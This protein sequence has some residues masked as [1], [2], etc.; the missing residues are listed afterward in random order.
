MRLVQSMK[1]FNQVLE[2]DYSIEVSDDLECSDVKV[3]A[4]IITISRQEVE[5]N[6]ERVRGELT[7]YPYNTVLQDELVILQKILEKEAQELTLL[8]YKYPD[9][10]I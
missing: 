4:Q 5:H 2:N 6:L 8:K 1:S 7:I 10:F 9:C 3:Q